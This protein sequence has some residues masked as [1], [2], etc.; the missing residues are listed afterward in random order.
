MHF[1]MQFF[2]KKAQTAS[3]H[4]LVSFGRRLTI[5]FYA[6]TRCAAFITANAIP[7][8][9]VSLYHQPMSYDLVFAV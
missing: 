6:S 3:K 5:Y 2:E 4:D 7:P 9:S 8:A 1:G